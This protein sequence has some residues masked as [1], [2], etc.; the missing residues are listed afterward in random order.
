LLANPIAVVFAS[1]SSAR[2]GKSIG[3]ARAKFRES[4]YD[5]PRAFACA[6]KAFTFYPE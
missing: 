2:A 1:Y 5:D 3:A 4:R 6:L